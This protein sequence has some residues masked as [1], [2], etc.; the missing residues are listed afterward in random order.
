[1]RK[2]IRIARLIG[3][4]ALIV[5]GGLVAAFFILALFVSDEPNRYWACSSWKPSRRG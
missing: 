4:S 1:M 5:A 3:C 2:A